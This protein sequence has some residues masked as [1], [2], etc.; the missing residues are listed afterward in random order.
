MRNDIFRVPKCAAFIGWAEWNFGNGSYKWLRLLMPEQKSSAGLI[1]NE[2]QTNQIVQ[3]QKSEQYYN[4]GEIDR[5][6]GG[7]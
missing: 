3:K 4:H 2:K 7:R 1:D 6:R 5:E